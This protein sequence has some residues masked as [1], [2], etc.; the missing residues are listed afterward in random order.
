MYTYDSTNILPC[1]E[2]IE[3]QYIPIYTK[4]IVVFLRC[5]SKNVPPQ[6]KKKKKSTVI[7]YFIY[8]S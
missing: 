2:K 8:T 6:K 1:D 3:V 4:D 7:I 5:I